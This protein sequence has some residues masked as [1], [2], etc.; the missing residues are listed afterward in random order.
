MKM[1]LRPYAS[2]GLVLSLA[3][4]LVSAGLYIVVREFNLALQISLGLVV[5]GLA[6]YAILDPERVRIALTGR[7]ARYGSNALVMTLALVG[8]VAVVNYLVYQNTNR[9]D[10]TEDEQFTLAPETL[11][12]LK[13]LPETVTAL[14][15]Y[16]QRLP[17]TQAEGLLDQY[18]FHSDGKFDYRFIN[19]EADPL[20]ANQ[21]NITRD[22]TIVLRMENHQ[23]QVTFTSEREMTAAL[24]RLLNPGEQAVY[25]LTGHGEYSPDESGEQ[26]YSQVKNAL[27]V[28]NYTVGTLNL[29]AV[30]QIPEDAQVIV[31]AGPTKPV[32]AAE[33]E[34]LKGFVGNGGALIALQEPLPLTDFGDEADPLAEYLSQ[35]WGIVLGEDL[36][37]DLTSNQPFVAVENRY[38]DHLITERMPVTFFPTARSVTTQDE[39]AGLERV[40]L[41]FTAQQSWAETDLAALTAAGEQDE[42]PPINPDEGVDLM[43]PVPLAV[44]AEDFATRGRVVVFG[45]S[46]FASDSF[47]N[48]Y[49]NGDL[50]INAI[51]WAAEQEELI[52]L[53]PKDNITRL[54]VPPQRYTMNLILL[55]SVFVL[56]GTVLLAGI[57][58]W[59]QRRRRG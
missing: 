6:L 34:L 2:L 9:W 25:F 27:E 32:S 35:E 37:V 20:A 54:L 48:Q 52:S 21:A 40:E 43:G 55:G 51:D 36:V 29:L 46:D 1:Q 14:A 38:G 56:P 50:L 26:S 47:F 42:P 12:A 11:E 58:V 4:A 30:N 10:L 24:V 57:L 41:V 33:I 23:E 15:F 13:R 5:I 49:G 3:A 59:F 44:A 19:P 45:D 18:K 17:T 8:I 28:K 53:T 22:G 7:Q 16:T 39:P 31:V